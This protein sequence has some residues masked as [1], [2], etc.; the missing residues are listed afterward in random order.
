MKTVDVEGLSESERTSRLLKGLTQYG[1]KI[2]IDNFIR[3]LQS[4]GLTPVVAGLKEHKMASIG[5][6]EKPVM[7]SYSVCKINVEC[8]FYVSQMRTDPVADPE[9]FPEKRFIIQSIGEF[10]A[11]LTAFFEGGTAKLFSENCCE[12]K[13][14]RMWKPQ[15]EWCTVHKERVNPFGHCRTFEILSR[16]NGELS[17]FNKE[18]CRK[19]AADYANSM[20]KMRPAGKIYLEEKD[21]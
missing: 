15:E 13:H 14:F 16:Y 9:K 11:W 17:V 8:A 20:K 21:E 12:C 7:I 18:L 2:Q 5:A 10:N 3:L 1:Y 19:N 4:R 6:Y